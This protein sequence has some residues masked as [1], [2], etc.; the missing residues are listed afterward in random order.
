M[1]NT[2]QVEL[3][4]EAVTSCLTMTS[5]KTELFAKSLSR[6]EMTLNQ[7]S[8]DASVDTSVDILLALGYDF[9]WVQNKFKPI[10][11][12][13]LDSFLELNRQKGQLWR[14]N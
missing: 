9:D 14:F 8:V 3:P 12:E 1:K 10:F 13:Q 4:R 11:Q 6:A 7:E 2:V 5:E